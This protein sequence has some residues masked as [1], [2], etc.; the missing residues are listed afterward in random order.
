[1]SVLN[2]KSRDAWTRKTF[3]GQSV[4]CFFCGEAVS[5]VAVH[6]H[7]TDWSDARAV[8]MILHPTCA[9][10]LGVKISSDAQ[11]AD[12]ILNG[13]PLTAGIDPSLLSQGEA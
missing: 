11:I 1:M 7:G 6:W 12:R 13:K 8:E 2:L 10:T 3:G 4:C 9:T 5:N